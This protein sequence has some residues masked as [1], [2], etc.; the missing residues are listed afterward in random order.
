MGGEGEQYVPAAA[1][2]RRLGREVSD[3]QALP[4]PV[5]RTAGPTSE[6]RTQC[7]RLVSQMHRIAV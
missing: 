5:R 4:R 7:R 2:W 3:A 1:A 6:E